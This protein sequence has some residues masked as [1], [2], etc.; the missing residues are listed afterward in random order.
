MKSF[1]EN[2]NQS[3][4]GLINTDEE[5]YIIQIIGKV[6]RSSYQAVFEKLLKSHKEY[7]FNK[8]ILNIK[9]LQNN[10]DFGRQWFTTYF[11]RRFYK[12]T[13][14]FFLAIVN[15][16]NKIERTSMSLIY[17][18]IERLGVKVSLKFF[19][20]VAEAQDWIVEVEEHEA[21][22]FMANKESFAPDKIIQTAKQV[23]LRNNKLKVKVQFSP[24]GSLKP[25]NDPI[26]LPSL[27]LKENLLKI[28]D[29]FKIPNLNY[30]K[31]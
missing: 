20:T 1:Y 28:K 29:N 5:F 9:E 27:N 6:S 25:D 3:I 17:G 21:I 16:K 26:S 4:T 10:P 13:G 2:P 12:I 22:N 7:S 23:K 8:L 24:T 31:K 19:D 14:G 30:K 11:M 18:M 15:P